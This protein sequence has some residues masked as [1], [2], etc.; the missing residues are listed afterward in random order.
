MSERQPI[1][2]NLQ[3]LPERLLP[4]LLGLPILWHEP[5]GIGKIWKSKRLI[6]H[7]SKPLKQLLPYHFSTRC[8]PVCRSA[9]KRYHPSNQVPHVLD[10]E[11]FQ[12]ILDWPQEETRVSLRREI[13]SPVCQSP[14]HSLLLPRP[15]ECVQF[16]QIHRNF[17]FVY[18]LH[19]L[20]LNFL[21]FFKKL[22]SRIL[23]SPCKPDAI[24]IIL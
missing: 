2:I 21:M 8:T 5:T 20:Y 7:K 11:L 19:M 4:G 6:L 24:D 12:G 14:Y 3:L 23:V 22:K 16:V 10:I 9:I 15:D 18:Y 13:C 1:C 17:N